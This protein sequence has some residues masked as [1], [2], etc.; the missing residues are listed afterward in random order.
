MMQAPFFE[1]VKM[2]INS[3][4]CAIFGHIEC[5][6]HIIWE[7]PTTGKMRTTCKRCGGVFEIE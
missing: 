2:C 3:T 7:D 6:T 4:L 5:E 1:R